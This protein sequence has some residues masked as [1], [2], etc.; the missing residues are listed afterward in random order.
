MRSVLSQTYR[1]L[2]IIVVDDASPAPG[3]AQ[4]IQGL[5]TLDEPVRVVLHERNRGL[6]AA[7]N[8]GF[9]HARGNLLV[10]VD[11]DDALD[12]RFLEETVKRIQSTQADC[13]FTDLLLFGNSEG[14]A[15]LNL[16]PPADLLREQ[17]IPGAGVL[18][19]EALWAEV[20][21]YSEADAFRGGDEDWDYWL[22][23]LA[24]GFVAEHVPLPLYRYRIHTDSMS[25]TS[26]SYSA[27]LTRDLMYL[28]HREL[29]RALGG[30]RAFRAG[31]AQRGAIAALSRGEKSRA[32]RLA[33]KSL[34]LAPLQLETW[35][36]TRAVC[37]PLWL[38]RL[39]WKLQGRSGA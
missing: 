17:W 18:M 20:G 19:R 2:E 1:P 22:S 24:R 13:V 30:G 7:R 35:R 37:V 10:A 5:E 14:V 23:A 25:A 38:K 11:A 29:F 34:V 28:R 6:G 8:T 33:A 36:T 21:G 16:R 15:P 32:M 26:L 12:E 31:G 9:S 39:I 3:A 4:M 27:S